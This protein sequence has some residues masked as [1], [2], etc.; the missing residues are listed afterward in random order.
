MSSIG[1]SYKLCICT[2]QSIHAHGIKTSPMSCATTI[3]LSIAQ[4]ITTPFRWGW[5]S[6]HYVPLMWPYHLQLLKK[7]LFM[8]SLKLTR[9]TTSLTAFN[10]S[11]SR[12]TIYWTERMLS[13]R[14]VMIN[15]GCHTSS[16]WATILVTFVEGMPL[17]A[18]PQD[19]LAPIWTLCHH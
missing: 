10:T 15:I 13:T 11:T 3:E 14:S 18:L 7:I 6:S 17:W 2:T 8:S 9:L 5:D 19:S 4:L 16:R 1:W 12:S